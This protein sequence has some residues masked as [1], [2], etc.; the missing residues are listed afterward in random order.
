MGRRGRRARSG[1]ALPGAQPAPDGILPGSVP[2]P[3]EFVARLGGIFPLSVLPRVEQSFLDPRVVGVRLN[4]LRGPVCEV[5]EWA[6]CSGIALTPLA[7]QPTG[8]FAA[9]ADRERLT[10]STLAEE[11]RFY[12]QAPSSQYMSL[13]LDPQPGETV[14]DLAAAPGGKTTHLAA[15]MENRG[16]LSA[17][18]AIRPRFFRLQ[19]SLRRMGVSHCRTF[20]M[21]GRSVARKTGPRFDRVL[22]DAPCS[23]ESRMNRMD[24]RSLQIWSPRKIAEC[25]RKQSG[26]IESAFQA[27]RPGG[28]LL[29]CTCSFAPEEN[30]RVVT[31]L[32]ETHPGEVRMLVP[33]HLPFESLPG[34]ASFRGE[35]FPEEIQCARRIVPGP[36]MDGFFLALLEKAGS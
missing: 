29:Y 1:S 31:R 10:H 35:R 27:L 33:E 6:A 2:L 19:A 5:L 13:L 22:L 21:D 11:G 7:G 16:T 32:L 30:E 4:P 12:V 28:R 3:A 36:V 14:L 23:S 25:S 18:E 34:L 26:L 8:F 15:L 20:L 24:P 9:P 17:V